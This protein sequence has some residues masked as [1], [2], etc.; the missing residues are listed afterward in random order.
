M[1]MRICQRRR[2]TGRNIGG[3]E[4]Y[5]EEDPKGQQVVRLASAATGW[6][7][8]TWMVLSGYPPGT[9]LHVLDVVRTAGGAAA[10]NEARR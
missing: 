10:G 8:E 9:W 1:E 5:Q 3:K 4:S 6:S 2:K 7:I